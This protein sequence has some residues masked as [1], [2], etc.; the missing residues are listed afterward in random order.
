M[1]ANRL[2]IAGLMTI[3]GVFALDC[4][5]QVRG[6]D[7]GDRTPGM[8]IFPPGRCPAR[9]KCCGGRHAS[10]TSAD[11]TTIEERKEK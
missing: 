1:G 6:I 11:R 2:S 3:V 8:A 7:L 4:A 9:G 10:H 5:V